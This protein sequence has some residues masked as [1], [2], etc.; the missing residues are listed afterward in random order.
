MTDP[1]NKHDD[2]LDKIWEQILQSQTNGNYEKIDEIIYLNPEYK[3]EIADKLKKLREVEE[4]LQPNFP[5][6][7]VP[8]C[9]GPFKII[10]KIG[11][12]G[13][14]CI[15]KAYDTNL[16]NREIALKLLPTLFSDHKYAIDK[17][18]KEAYLAIELNHP[19]IVRVYDFGN[20]ENHYFISM[21]YIS[22]VTLQEKISSSS[23][24]T[25]SLDETLNIIEGVALGLLYA[26]SKTTPVIHRD[27]KPANIMITEDGTI[28]VLD[29]GIAREMKDVYTTITNNAPEISGTLPYMSPEQLTGKTPHPSMD[30]YSLGITAYECLAGKPPFH[31]GSIEYQIRNEKPRNIEGV[32][33]LTMLALQKALS[34]NPLNRPSTAI[35][36]I[37]LFKSSSAEIT[38]H[39]STPLPI[40]TTLEEYINAKY[41]YI[42]SE[43]FSVDMKCV[44]D[45]FGNRYFSSHSRSTY[46]EHLRSI[47]LQAIKDTFSFSE[48]KYK[49][50]PIERRFLRSNHFTE[51]EEIMLLYE[52][53]SYL[54]PNDNKTTAMSKIFFE[55]IRPGPSGMEEAFTLLVDRLNSFQKDICDDLKVLLA[56]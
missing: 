24:G 22:G 31:S 6:S 19:N 41:E 47:F 55:F 51:Y 44:E 5:V 1:Y 10:N 32:P 15:Y 8:E 38:T 39:R 11:Q 28:K 34:K 27:L 48:Y 7:N 53:S 45:A 26:H 13:M 35:D 33:E 12:G 23:T 2:T 50:L 9:I 29:F 20:I 25:L 43:C 42:F 21:E 49:Y 14:G 54:H 36:F 18:R 37:N 17:M 16:C 4:L 52:N 56:N 40:S 3:T 30:I 46:L